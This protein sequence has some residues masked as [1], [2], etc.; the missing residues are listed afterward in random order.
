MGKEFL[1]N[2]LGEQSNSAQCS[3]RLSCD[4][5]SWN[6]LFLVSGETHSDAATVLSPAMP[7]WTDRMT[8]QSQS[9]RDLE[10]LSLRESIKPLFPEVST[11][12]PVSLR[13]CLCACHDVYHFEHLSVILY[14]LSYHLLCSSISLT[15]SRSVYLPLSPRLSLRNLTL[16]L[17]LVFFRAWLVGWPT[18]GLIRVTYR[19]EAGT[20]THINMNAQ[21]AHS[22]VCWH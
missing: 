10:A 13:T 2:S 5:L 22:A 4:L 18:S 3:C 20:H 6:S 14:H 12:L 17:S 11:L 7:G 21:A 1:F 9:H 19:R 15:R 8:A 16:L